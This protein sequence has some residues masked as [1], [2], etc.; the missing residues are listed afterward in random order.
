[1]CTY[2]RVC[3]YI[4]IHIYI[5]LHTRTYIHILCICVYMYIYIYISARIDRKDPRC[6]FLEC[7]Y[8]PTC[9]F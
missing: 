3:K 9:V 1:M 6:S 4:Y 5:Y 8:I 2:V 7:V